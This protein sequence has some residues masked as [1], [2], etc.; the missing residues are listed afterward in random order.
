[1]TY[2]GV[3]CPACEWVRVR[4]EDVLLLI[5][6]DGTATSRL[7]ADC[8]CCDDAISMP[9]SDREVLQ[10]LTFDVAFEGLTRG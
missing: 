5:G 1:M 10:L 2:L 3:R 4:T 8:P 7:D 9:A 6:L